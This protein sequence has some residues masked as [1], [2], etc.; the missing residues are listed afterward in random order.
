MSTMKVLLFVVL[1]AALPVR[2]QVL[3]VPNS[4]FPV[5]V[6]VQ[7]PAETKTALQAVCVFQS[8]PG[9]T[10]HGSLTEIDQKLGGLLSEIRKN[11]LFR[12]ALG[13][14]LLIVP[15]PGSLQAR[16][17][18]VI[19][20]GDRESF[21]PDREQVVGFLLFQAAEGLGVSHP[22]FAP[23]VLD[24][25]MTGTDTGE[26]AQQFLSGFLRA[27]ASHDLLRRRGVAAASTP[28]GLT[29]LAGKTHAERTRD[30][31][32]LAFKTAAR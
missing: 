27:K 10:F 26:V 32:A 8:D 21:S 1:F 28:Q 9:N 22:Y 23:T 12:G 14:T 5:Q 24:A 30:G 6:L 20:L 15:K 2:A 11:D 17:L 16:R 19:G 18:L 31:L 13:E 4:S 3:A 7:S 29:F 25:G